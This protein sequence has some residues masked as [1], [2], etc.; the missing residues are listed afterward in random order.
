MIYVV[1]TSGQNR[2]KATCGSVFL[3]TWH[4]ILS[5]ELTKT[6]SFRLFSA[7]LPTG[8]DLILLKSISIQFFVVVY[9]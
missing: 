2:R 4:R 6:H 3:T 5:T 8:M 9:I 1:Y 7:I